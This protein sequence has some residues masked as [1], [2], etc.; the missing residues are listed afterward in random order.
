MKSSKPSWR[1]FRAFMTIA[2]NTLATIT[3]G[4]QLIQAFFTWLWRWHWP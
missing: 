2:L 1:A 4:I 3:S